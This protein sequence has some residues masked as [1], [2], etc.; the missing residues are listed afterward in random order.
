MLRRRGA[1]DHS[2][3]AS[4]AS[5]VSPF[6]RALTKGHAGA[7]PPRILFQAASPG[8]VV[9]P[10][11]SATSS[12]FLSAASLPKGVR[13]QSTIRTSHSR[14]ERKRNSS[15][16][17]MALVGFDLDE[18]AKRPAAGTSRTST[19]SQPPSPKTPQ[20]SARSS[21]SSSMQLEAP[22][23]DLD[24]AR[25]NHS[26][27][28]LRGHPRCMPNLVQVTFTKVHGGACPILSWFHLC[29]SYPICKDIKTN[30]CNMSE[31]GLWA[32]YA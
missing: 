1:S 14:S 32:R 17:E 25:Q 5:V 11:D 30:A 18:H 7:S 20:Q 9:S 13:P 31:A 19:D 26:K 3:V 23:Q 16:L 2:H 6:E 21:D 8:N 22:Y 29:N 4:C 12:D 28:P 10:F 27:N 24:S 15:S